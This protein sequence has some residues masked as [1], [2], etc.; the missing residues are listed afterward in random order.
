MTGRKKQKTEVAGVS[1]RPIRVKR[2]ESLA[3]QVYLT[4]RQQMHRGD[5]AP[6]ARLVDVEIAEKLGVS[7]MPVREALMRLVHEGY[8]IGTTRGFVPTQL[9][10]AD[11]TEIFEVRA[12]LEPRAAAQAASRLKGLDLAQLTEARNRAVAA[13]EAGDA[14]ALML[15]NI[16]FR[17]IWLNAA[18]NRRLA[19]TIG[20]FVDHVQVVRLATL[21][22]PETQKI[23]IDGLEGLHAAFLAHDPVAAEARMRAFIAKAEESFFE[24]MAEREAAARQLARKSAR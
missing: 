16:A 2:Q 3:H 14:E 8:L 17:S 6:D 12:L 15:A 7:R 9:T 23:V 21:R 13:H 5:I 18:G 11:I 10:L 22:R 1:V 19:A 24:A 20:R 4:L